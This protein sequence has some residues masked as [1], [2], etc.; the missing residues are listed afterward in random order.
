M[1]A[2]LTPLFLFVL[3]AT[4]SPGG[5]TTLAT[6]SGVN[7][8]FTRSLPLLTGIS[9][10]LGAMAAMAGLGLSTI[11]LELPVLQLTMKAVGTAYLFW[12]ALQ[13]AQR[14][15]P[16]LEKHIAKPTSAL[17]GIGLL[18]IN[19]K[20]WAMTLG[21][22]ASFA[23]LADSPWRLAILLGL[24]FALFSAFALTVWCSVGILLGRLLKT[25]SQWR[26]LNIVM[27]LLLALSVVPMWFE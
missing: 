27:G 10:G 15:R 25:V 8:G 6:A 22:A 18:W 24:T 17:A 1:V 7:F 19:P 9:V 5:A 2:S 12:L 13:T 23:A 4:I 16:D 20:G 3:I 11:L 21:A 14:G 26:A